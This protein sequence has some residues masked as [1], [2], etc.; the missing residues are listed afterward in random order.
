MSQSR[1]KYS[2]PIL[3][4]TTSWTPE[5]IGA[6]Q[7]AEMKQLLANAERL[8]EDEIAALCR[9]AIKARPRPAPAV[10]PGVKAAAK[11]KAKVAVA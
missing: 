9:Q 10:K 1:T 6:L 5:R 11:P 3:S 7:L 2:A 8:Q 4:R